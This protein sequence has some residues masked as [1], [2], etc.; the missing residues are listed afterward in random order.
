GLKEDFD[1][2]DGGDEGLQALVRIEEE[3]AAGNDQH[4]IG[5]PDRTADQAAIGGGLRR[6]EVAAVMIRPETGEAAN[7]RENVAQRIVDRNPSGVVQAGEP[8][9]EWDR[10]LLIDDAPLARC[11]IVA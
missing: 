4:P 3:S 11:E 6:I 9:W 5:V 2:A 10:N 1:I 7:V 8:D